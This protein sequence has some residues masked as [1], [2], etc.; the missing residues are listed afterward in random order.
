MTVLQVPFWQEAVGQ[1]ISPHITVPAGQPAGTQDPSMQ[2]SPTLQGVMQTR[3]GHLPALQ[4]APP[5]QPQV[6]PQPL[7]PPQVP[8]MGQWGMQHL[9]LTQRPSGHPHRPPQPLGVPQVPSAGQ[10]GVQHLPMAQLAPL[11]VQPQ[12]PPQPSAPPQVPSMGQLGT[13]HFPIRQA[14]LL[15]QPQVPPQPSAPPQVP[16]VGHLGAQHLPPVHWAPAGQPHLPPQPLS[17][18]H[19]PSVGQL[20]VHTQ[21]PCTQ[22]PLPG[23]GVAQA[24]VSM[25]LPLLHN[26]P[27]AQ[28]TPAH[29][30]TTQVLRTQVWPAGHWTPAQSLGGVGAAQVRWQAVPVGHMP[31][32]GRR[33]SQ[34]P[35]PGLQN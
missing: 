10:L 15:G 29:E 1:Q 24:Q 9:P 6:P 27:A 30:S 25:H 33:A 5:W 26:W 21:R 17:P 7:S 35:V 4:A 16:S 13:Q 32:Q 18:P 34:R 22:R 19:V 8:S 31:L 23:Q 3:G 2:T 11:A 28:V 20:G 12:V 14:R